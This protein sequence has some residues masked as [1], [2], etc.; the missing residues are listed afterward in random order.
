MLIQN[1]I[2]NARKSLDDFV[3]GYGNKLTDKVT[4]KVLGS[5]LTKKLGFGLGNI[6]T[7]NL[8]FS[9]IGATAGALSPFAIGYAISPDFDPYHISRILQAGVYT[10]MA[11][12]LSIG[13]GVV[14]GVEGCL[15]GAWLDS[16]IKKQYNK[17][18]YLVS[19]H[20]GVEIRDWQLPYD[21]KKYRAGVGG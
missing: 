15:A 17:V 9:R 2:A 4:H 8:S 5:A 13:I 19:K 20:T 12:P 10:V 14:L 18:A 7:T 6:L 3:L 21:C 11:F 16:R 1:K